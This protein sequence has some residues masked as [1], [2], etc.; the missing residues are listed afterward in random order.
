M[1][2]NIL[3]TT[4]NDF[5]WTNP[6]IAWLG[7]FF[8]WHYFDM[9]STSDH[10]NNYID[11]SSAPKTDVDRFFNFISRK[12]KWNCKQAHFHGELKGGGEDPTKPRLQCLWIFI[13]A[14]FCYM[15]AS[16]DIFSWK[17]WKLFI[18]WM[19]NYSTP[20]QA[21][22]TAL[23]QKKYKMQLKKWNMLQ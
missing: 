13:R 21:K 22:L 23:L 18:R 10:Q 4:F 15:K 3:L 17:I 19:K 14:L 12:L 11:T 7:Y 1:D 6:S 20:P 8:F 2:S 5:F 16:I 9:I